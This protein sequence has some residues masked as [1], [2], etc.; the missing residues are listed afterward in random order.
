MF[1][2]SSL[3]E[4]TEDELEENDYSKE[5]QVSTRHIPERHAMSTEK[6]R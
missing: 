6:L 5:H 3:E 1:T 4:E 2:E